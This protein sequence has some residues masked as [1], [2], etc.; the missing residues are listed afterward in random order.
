[1]A[2]PA[3]T[4]SSTRSSPRPSGRLSRTCSSGGAAAASGGHTAHCGRDGDC[5]TS[6]G[7]GRQAQ[8]NHNKAMGHSGGTVQ[9]LTLQQTGTCLLFYLFIFICLRRSRGLWE[10]CRLYIFFCHDNSNNSEGRDSRGREPIWELGSSS[11]K[12]C[13]RSEF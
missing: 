5:F 1:M 10:L 4:R 11:V 8:S 12:F 6:P 3:S 13:H 7:P 9:E 2:T